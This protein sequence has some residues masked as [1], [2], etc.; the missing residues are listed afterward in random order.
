[1]L[2]DI[3]GFSPSTID[4][5][6][7]CAE[8]YSLVSRWDEAINAWNYIIVNFRNSDVT[9]RSWSNLQHAQIMKSLD[10]RHS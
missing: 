3:D 8:L 2:I 10:S 4:E 9:Q 5:W 7:V 6:L 1:M